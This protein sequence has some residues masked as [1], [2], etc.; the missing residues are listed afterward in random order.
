M[1]R[2]D[3]VRSASANVPIIAA[4]SYYYSESYVRITE[5]LLLSINQLLLQAC[6]QRE[7]GEI[8]A[9][10]YTAVYRDN[11]AKFIAL[12][13]G[14]SATPTAEAAAEAFEPDGRGEGNPDSLVQDIRD[15]V[16]TALQTLAGD[17]EAVRG[18]LADM[19]TEIRNDRARLLTRDSVLSALFDRPD[20]GASRESRSSAAVTAP[21]E[22]IE[23]LVVAFDTDSAVVSAADRDRL[24]AFGERTCCDR[25]Y[26]I[27]G[28]ADISGTV[29]HNDALSSLRALQVSEAL[30]TA[31]PDAVVV[32]TGMGE[33]AFLGSDFKDNRIVYVV[34]LKKP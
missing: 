2:P 4:G 5:P 24:T 19:Q 30:R 22:I 28:F 34:A 10:E 13:R 18:A 20:N 23:G 6:I 7:M 14:F 25:R 29:E 17:S 16:D 33:G 1:F 9:Q 32:E 12:A 31:V 11:S 15:E 3:V 8:T 26:A 27:Y 21:R